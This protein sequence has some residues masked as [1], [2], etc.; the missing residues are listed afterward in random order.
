MSAP[1]Q[2]ERHGRSGAAKRLRQLGA[3][4]KAEYRRPGEAIYFSGAANV[5][6]LVS[7]EAGGYLFSFSKACPCS[8]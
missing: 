6:I 1:F 4:E 5:W 2:T 8:D 3:V 7:Q